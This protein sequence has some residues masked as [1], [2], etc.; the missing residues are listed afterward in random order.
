[1]SYTHSCFNDTLV[2]PSAEHLLLDLLSRPITSWAVSTSS[3]E[4]IFLFTAVLCFSENNSCL[5]F[6][7][8]P[9]R[10]TSLLCS[11]S[12]GVG[13]GDDFSSLKS[14]PWVNFL[15][16]LLLMSRR[17]L[18]LISLAKILLPRETFELHSVPHLMIKIWF[19]STKLWIFHTP[20]PVWVDATFTSCKHYYDYPAAA[21]GQ[22]Q[23]VVG[24]DSIS[25]F[26]S[27]PCCRCTEDIQH[28]CGWPT[29]CRAD[30]INYAW[31]PNSDAPVINLRLSSI[32]H[33][34]VNGG[35]DWRD[36]QPLWTKRHNRHCVE[37]GQE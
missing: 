30:Q 19:S 25:I 34:A 17:L 7:P 29:W 3:D 6:S 13:I 9:A 14:Q 12:V 15:S 11:F 22:L 28:Q 26:S 32:F 31:G 33:Q 23:N 5:T 18:A 2:H 20:P 1:M 16:P 36:Q 24:D 35:S 21:V 8:P 4:L 27:A 37:L 10:A